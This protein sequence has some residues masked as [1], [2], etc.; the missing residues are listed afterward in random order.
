M[1]HL[2]AATAAAA[3]LLA[4]TACSQVGGLVSPTP[5]P[6]VEPTPTPTAT[7]LPVA[8]PLTG[9]E[10]SFADTRPVAVTLRTGEGTAPLWGVSNAEVLVQGV[11]EG[12]TAGLMAL[13]S[14]PA[15]AAKIGPVGPGRDLLL[16]FALPLNAVPVHIGKN[17]YAGNLLNVLTYQDIDGLHI[18]KAA[19]AFDE[20]RQQSGYREEN[21]WYTTPELLQAGLDYYGASL[22]GSN[23]P[24]FRFGVRPAVADDARNGTELALTYSAS[25][26]VRFSYNAEQKVYRMQDADGNALVDADNGQEVAFTNL[27]VLYAS[28][29]IKDDGYTRQYDLSGGAGLYLTEGA[30]QTIQWSKGDA[31]APLTLLDGDGMPLT[32]SPGK[33]YIGVW[34]GYYGQA[35]AVY[36]ADGS[37]QTL[38]DKPALLESGV[39]DE[40]AA[41]AE[42]EYQTYLAVQTAQEELETLRPQLETALVTLQEAQA[43][44]ESAGPDDEAAA[45]ALT[46]AQAIVDQ[47]QAKINERQAIIDAANPPAEET[48]AEET[49]AEE[50]AEA[51]SGE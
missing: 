39:S 25:D 7:P 13:F 47:L 27:L 36:A 8:D 38:P 29:G 50:G 1:K 14:N 41:A 11:T 12:Y 6:T 17:V 45:A 16:Q 22:T 32:V 51:A 33:S 19:F 3:L 46:E 44:A 20:D 42:A 26:T 28:S 49:P 31:T 9:Q 30:W 4:L 15:D 40:A 23:T 35:I 21:C 10:G 18:G 37:A 24:L 48:P 5:T 34:G 43:A 2:Q